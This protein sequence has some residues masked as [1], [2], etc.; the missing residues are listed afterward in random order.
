MNRRVFATLIL[1]AAVLFSCNAAQAITINPSEATSKDT[2]GYQFLPAMNLNGGGFGSFLPAGK[3]STGHDTKSILEFDLTGVGLTGAQVSS[4]TLNLYI[5]DSPETGFGISPTPGAPITVNLSALTAA[6]DEST[7]GWS[8][9][10][11]S[12]AEYDSLVINGINQIV[13]FD[14]TF[15]VQDW[16]NGDLVN[17]GLI[18]EADAAVGLSPDWVYAVFASSGNTNYTIPSLTITPVPEPST[19]VLAFCAVPALAWVAIR[20][21]N[22]QS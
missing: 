5:I 8:T 10:P 19:I 13:S 7:V 3:T 20:R 18:L 1:T 11:A 22:R 21:K 2:F 16:L 4:A 17:N 6:W 14:V 9:I 15:L 12:G